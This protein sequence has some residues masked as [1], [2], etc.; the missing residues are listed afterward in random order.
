VGL[1]RKRTKRLI[2]KEKEQFVRQQKR[3][4]VRQSA[5]GRKPRD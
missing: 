3:Q 4:K 5:G 1:E 2:G